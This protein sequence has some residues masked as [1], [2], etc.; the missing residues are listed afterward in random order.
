MGTQER[1]NQFSF[2]S[3]FD[4]VFGNKVILKKK[5]KKS[6]IHWRKLRKINEMR[7]SETKRETIEDDD[8]VEESQNSFDTNAVVPNNTLS[9]YDEISKQDFDAPGVIDD[10][11]NLSPSKISIPMS[12][13]KEDDNKEVV[14]SLDDSSLE[15][16]KKFPRDC[17]NSSSTHINS[18]SVKDAIISSEES[19][20]EAPPLPNNIKATFLN[21]ERTTYENCLTN[22]QIVHPMIGIQS[23]KS[24]QICDKPPANETLALTTTYMESNNLITNCDN[25]GKEM[26]EEQKSEPSELLPQLTGIVNDSQNDLQ[27]EQKVENISSKLSIKSWSKCDKDIENIN[28]CIN[29]SM[30]ES[31]GI[32]ILRSEHGNIQNLSGPS[33]PFE[34]SEKVEEENL[35][36]PIIAKV[37]SN[38]PVLNFTKQYLNEHTPNIESPAESTKLC[39]SIPPAAIPPVQENVNNTNIDHFSHTEE[40]R[41]TTMPSRTFSKPPLT[42][43]MLVMIA[44]QNEPCLRSEESSQLSTSDSTLSRYRIIEFLQY[45]FPFFATQSAIKREYAKKLVVEVLKN[46]EEG[47]QIC[48]Q[49]NDLQEFYPCL[50]SA[51]DEKLQDILNSM[52]C[53]YMLEFFL[54]NCQPKPTFFRKPPFSYLALVDI[55]ISYLAKLYPETVWIHQDEVVTFI[56]T[57]F[58]F[59]RYV[60]N[61]IYTGLLVT[62]NGVKDQQ[63]TFFFLC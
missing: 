8:T 62:N 48:I 34:Q 63:L 28:K 26:C 36:I 5:G 60:F 39:A 17:I 33:I 27:V 1:L 25:Q 7:E 4:G 43:N 38:S 37:V 24:L 40:D 57:V 56:Q 15:S 23:Q 18:T 3:Q 19:E 51:C 2:V 59:F 9:I 22:K 11:F 55:A 20:N 54:L 12:N 30:V 41:I 32:E 16:F 61:P 52:R 29:Y 6:K 21:E 50:R 14:H 53:P 46:V 35:S 10:E 13:S 45:H 47:E 49:F 31:N 42:A 58:P 44:I